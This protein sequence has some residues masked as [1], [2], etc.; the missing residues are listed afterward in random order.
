MTT[1]TQVE[2]MVAEALV[3]TGRGAVME[4]EAAGTGTLVVGVPAEAISANGRDQ[5]MKVKVAIRRGSLC[6]W[7]EPLCDCN[8]HGS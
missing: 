2:A 4:N 7:L 5:L 6:L 1:E 3:V 8:L